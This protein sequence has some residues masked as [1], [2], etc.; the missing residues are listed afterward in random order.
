VIYFRRR[1]SPY[2][3][4]CRALQEPLAPPLGHTPHTQITDRS[5]PPSWASS[6]GPWVGQTFYKTRSWSQTVHSSPETDRVMDLWTYEYRGAQSYRKRCGRFFGQILH[7]PCCHRRHCQN[8]SVTALGEGSRLLS[9]NFW[10]SG[11]PPL[12]SVRFKLTCAVTSNGCEMLVWRL[13][14]KNGLI[15]PVEECLRGPP[16]PPRFGAPSSRTGKIPARATAVK[17]GRRPVGPIDDRMCQIR[18]FLHVCFSEWGRRDPAAI[19]A[20]KPPTMS[21]ASN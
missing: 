10:R 3:P 4:I 21:V 1:L 11:Q 5:D 16:P 2:K 7:Q 19:S 17:L 8:K 15:N 18:P 9:P 20:P 6:S 14:R 12:Q 13:S